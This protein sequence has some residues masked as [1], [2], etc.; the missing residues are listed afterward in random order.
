MPHFPTL[1]LLLAF[2]Y[3]LVAAFFLLGL[4]IGREE[5]KDEIEGLYQ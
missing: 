5:C 1:R 4:G 3:C 2:C